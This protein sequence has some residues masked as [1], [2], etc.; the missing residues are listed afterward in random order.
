MNAMQPLLAVCPWVPIIGNH[1]SSDGDGSFRCGNVFRAHFRHQGTSKNRTFAKTGSGQTKEMLTKK[2]V[3][4][5]RYLNQTF[6]M[7][8]AN[9]LNGSVSSATTALSHLLTKG[10]YLAPLVPFCTK[11]PNIYQ[12][13]LRTNI[14]IGKAD[15]KNAVR[16]ALSRLLAKG[17]YLA[18]GLHGTTPSGT[19]SYFSVDIGLIHITVS[20]GRK[21]PLFLD[22]TVSLF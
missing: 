13:R 4:F 19:S 5:C 22:I 3:S 12:D 9:P 10:S 1:E 17:S 16:Y 2:Y 20:G 7:V 21:T 18:P 11:N 6:G 8:Y 14:Y 15:T